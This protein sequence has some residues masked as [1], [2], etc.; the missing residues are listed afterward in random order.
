MQRYRKFIVALVGVIISILLVRYGH[1]DA[2]VND[3]ILIATA[4][5][6]YAVPNNPTI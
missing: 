5:G 4:L 2:V 3:V 1:S 6:V